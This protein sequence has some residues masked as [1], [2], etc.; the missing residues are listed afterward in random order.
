MRCRFD[1]CARDVR[2]WDSGRVCAN[3]PAMRALLG[4]ALL[5][6]LTLSGSRL[7]R[8]QTPHATETRTETAGAS[9]DV[10]HR[11]PGADDANHPAATE[12]AAAA[13]STTPPFSL[14]G[15][16]EAFYQWNF[17]DPSNGITNF[18]GFDN[19]HNTFT[20][21][22]VALDASW[23]YE[24]LVGRVALQ[25]GHTPSTYYLAEPRAAGTDATSATG[26]EVWKYVQ[27]A[28]AGYRFDVARGLTVSAGVFLSPIGPE[29]VP[30]RDS[31]NWSRSNLFVGLP[32]Y[33]AGARAALALTDA[34]TVTLAV[35]NGWN[36]VVDGND[37]KSISAQLAYA[38]DDFSMSILYFGG[39]ERPRGAPEGRA[40]RHLLD[41]YATWRATRRLSLLAHVDGGLEPNALGLSAWIAGALAVRFRLAEA[42][43]IAARGDAFHERVADGAEG[44]ATPIF[45]PAPWVASGTATLEYRPHERVSI[46]L[47]YRHDQAGADLYFG[48]AVSGDGSTMPY[49]PNRAGQDTVTLGATSWF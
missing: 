39:V 33:H 18:R 11:A 36:S 44:R 32:F 42:W 24:G 17:G 43:S 8:A 26:P 28:Q 21:A 29:S 46:R 6:T 27:Q 7:A 49:A 47:E 4:L 16:A 15:Y 45:F 1:A 35:Y 48:G 22:N 23:D 12:S 31:W 25:V 10:A 3:N 13:A 30:I 34:W 37:D 38:R 2:M 41:A 9:P 5:A 20:L 14:S 19:R 40:F